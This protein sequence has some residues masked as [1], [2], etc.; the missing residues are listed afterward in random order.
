MVKNG[1]GWPC[2]GMTEGRV[3][4]PYSGL[5]LGPSLGFSSSLLGYLSTDGIFK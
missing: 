5:K 3:D 2:K 1:M 4:T